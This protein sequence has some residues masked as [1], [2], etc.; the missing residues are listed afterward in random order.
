MDPQTSP[1]KRMTR[2]RAAKVGESSTAKTTKIVTASAK[3][4]ATRST[5]TSATKRKTRA[6]EVEDDENNDQQ[7]ELAQPEPA[8]KTRTRGRPK[9]AAEPEPEVEAA[10]ATRTRGRPKK[11]AEPSKEEPQPTKP[12]TRTTRTKK[13]A[14]PE[15][16]APAE[17]AKKPATR[18]RGS[19][20]APT[21]STA[22][23]SATAKKTVKFEEPEKENIEPAPTKT[24]RGKAAETATTGLRAKPVR[25]TVASSTA[26]RASTRAGAGTAK[27]S[28]QESKYEKPTPLS[29][30]KVTQMAMHNRANITKSDS[31]APE[32]EDELAADEKTTAKP[33][34]KAMSGVR[35]R[36]GMKLQVPRPVPKPTSDENEVENEV[37]VSTV[38]LGSPCRRPPPSPWKDSLKT[39]AKRADGLP[40]LAQSAVR[41]PA[42]L[43]D[44][45]TGQQQQQQPQSALKTSLFASPAKRSQSA[46]NGLALHPAG[47]MQLTAPSPFKT[48][49]LSPPKRPMSPN[50]PSFLGLGSPQKQQEDE[51]MFGRSPAP[52]PTLLATPLVAEH[53]D[54]QGNGLSAGELDIPEDVEEEE[55]EREPNRLLFPGRMSAVLP[56]HADPALDQE[57]SKHEESDR[58]E[59]HQ[60]EHPKED[61]VDLVADDIQQVEEHVD[62]PMHL[63]E[64]EPETVMARSEREF[65]TTPPASPP[66]QQQQNAGFF[67]LREK[68]LNPM[69]DQEDTESEDE[70]ELATN[71]NLMPA[72]PCPATSRTTTG[73]NNAMSVRSANFGDR[74]SVK[75]ARTDDKFGFTP[76][77]GRLNA[78][79]VASSPLKMGRPESPGIDVLSQ[80]DDEAQTV[81]QTKTPGTA[82]PMRNTYFDE[83]I[84]QTNIEEH[85]E[86]NNE[87]Q[88]EEP[89]TSEPMDTEDGVLTP[90]FDDIPVTE[91]DVSLAAEANE[92]SLM[93][94]AQVEDMLH[95][96]ALSEASQ[97]Y[98]DE[99]AI[100]IDP[101]LLVPPTTPQRNFSEVRHVHTVS[102]VP[103]KPADDSTPRPRVKR[104]GHSISRLPVQRPTQGLQRNATVISYSPTKKATQIEE[105]EAEDRAE[106]APPVTPAKSEWSI[107]GTPARTPRR[108]L[109]PAL[110]RGAVV[111]VDVHTSEGADA[112][113]IFVELLSQ[114]GARCVK[115]W[116]WNPTSPPQD[117]G[118]RIGITHVV[119]KD[120]GKRTLE[121]VRESAGVVQCV[122]V[123]WV[124]E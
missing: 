124:L 112:S 73:N 53:S 70:D 1:P 15:S 21:K 7:D 94:P 4:K 26:A 5:A 47:G 63:D 113:G 71:E 25:R 109:N 79:G 75:R 102:K 91:E 13:T 60:E 68:D 2:A 14:E 52:K 85:H 93:E 111:F 49:L 77:T 101:T 31:N 3:A 43:F 6:D 41:P 86:Q 123:S 34:A 48:S 62:D 56:R 61:Q 18:T 38:I 82:S 55:E 72:T 100:P 104:R 17:P 54:G 40:A 58:E 117:G 98:G 83:A 8:M 46:M 36:G 9:K 51:T 115:S 66:N 107:A 23:K 116:P 87:Q 114:M 92:M 39:P 89:I 59:D 35:V 22:A 30:K 120:G 90:E 24:A 37:P 32:S 119:Y 110:L 105:T 16:E 33:K 67:G 118:S 44:G 10:P 95:D 80:E 81:P 97:E 96:D 78:W 45:E 19:A 88:V 74:S 64:P 65:T 99:N 42:R 12:A 50:K 76:L 108:D 28:G 121:K 27:T 84:A 122:G 57:E 103:T 106:S 11:A 20:T 29:P 69:H